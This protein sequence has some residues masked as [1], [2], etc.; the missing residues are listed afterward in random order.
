[1]YTYVRYMY[2]HICTHTYARIHTFMYEKKAQLENCLLRDS[3]LT[4][5]LSTYLAR[6]IFSRVG[7][8]LNLLY[9]ISMELTFEKFFLGMRCDD[10]HD[11][12]EVSEVSSLLE[13]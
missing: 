6:Q 7:S 8:L 11:K 12:K 1:M 2:T 4:C 10:A 5:G 13:S 9:K 3:S